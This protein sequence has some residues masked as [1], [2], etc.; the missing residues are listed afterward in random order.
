MELDVK[1]KIKMLKKLNPK[2]TTKD[3]SILLGKDAPPESEI[4]NIFNEILKGNHNEKKFNGK[5]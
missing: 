2:L 1:E 3:A 5:N 4:L